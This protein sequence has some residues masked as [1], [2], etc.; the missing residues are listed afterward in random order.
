MCCKDILIYNTFVS[1]ISDQ[2]F[3]TISKRGNSIFITFSHI[4]VVCLL[5]NHVM[6]VKLL[7]SLKK[8]VNFSLEIM[9]SNFDKA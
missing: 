8:S 2:C 5:C 3:A 4:R 7:Q 1:L 9:T 6:C